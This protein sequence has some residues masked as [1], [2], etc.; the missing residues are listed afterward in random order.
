LMAVGL[1]LDFDVDRQA[2]GWGLPS[3]WSSRRR[4]SAGPTVV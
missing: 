2:D 4:S 3:G 1:G